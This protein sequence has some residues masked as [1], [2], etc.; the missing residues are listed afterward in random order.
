MGE[1]LK[2]MVPLFGGMLLPVWIPL[3]G[4]SVGA[5][6]DR[7]RPATHTPAEKVVTDVKARSAARRASTPALAEVER[8][9]E[10]L[11]A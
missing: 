10:P 1:L 2:I 7:L 8:D 9:Y 4:V 6:T 11:A 3:I 5:L